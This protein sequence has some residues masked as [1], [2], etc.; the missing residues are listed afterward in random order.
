MAEKAFTGLTASV[1]LGANPSA[2]VLGYISGVNLDLE[3]N[4]IEVLQFG[5]QYKEKVPAIKDWSASVEGTAALVSDG[6]QKK[7]L[8]AFESGELLTFGI[9]LDETTYFQ[10]SGYVSTFHIDAQPDDK[11]NLSADIAGSGAVVLTLP[12]GGG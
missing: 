9:Y 5:A 1:K 3:K 11:I 7:L 12:G 4:I 2:E 10:G 6:S 8:D